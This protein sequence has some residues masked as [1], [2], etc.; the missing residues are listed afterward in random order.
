[1]AGNTSDNK[2]TE[3]YE[4]KEQLV[5]ATRTY[6]AMCQKARVAEPMDVPGLAAAAFEDMPLRAL[7]RTR[8]Q[9]PRLGLLE[10]EITRGVRATAQRDQ[11]PVETRR[12]VLVKGSV[13]TL[14]AG[15]SREHV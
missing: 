11:D 1:M 6:A 9:R 4:F 8:R 14:F 10:L 5:K 12:A 13:E 15:T 2:K 7:Q 3:R